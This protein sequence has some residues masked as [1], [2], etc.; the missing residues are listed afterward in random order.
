MTFSNTPGVLHINYFQDNVNGVEVT[1]WGFT[2]SLCMQ[3]ALVTYQSSQQFCFM[4]DLIT[5]KDNCFSITATRML[6]M[7]LLGNDLTTKL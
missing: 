3:V 2:A 6:G 4:D 7:S 1:T 5:D